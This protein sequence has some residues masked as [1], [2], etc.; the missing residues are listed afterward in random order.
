MGGFLSDG[1]FP[2]EIFALVADS[3]SGKSTFGES[4]FENPLVI[5]VEE[6]TNLDL[7]A[8][9]ADE[10]DGIVLDNV[11][12]WGQLLRWRAL[13]QARNAKS[14]GG[15]SSTNVYSYVQYLYGVPIVATLDL[16]APDKYYIDST[17]S[18]RSRWLLKNCVFVSL[19]AGRTFFKER[20]GPRPEIPNTYSLFAQ[21]LRR[22]RALSS[23][24]SC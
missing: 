15:Q 19:A 24:A 20:V 22:R 4:L 13:L 1:G 17:S 14:R 23:A 3:A 9:C 11:N 2:L 16:D 18:W 21:T 6:A 7:K 12:S 5:T 8:F 10:H